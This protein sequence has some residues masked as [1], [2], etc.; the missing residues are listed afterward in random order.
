[1]KSFDGLLLGVVFLSFF[2]NGRALA[3]DPPDPLFHSAADSAPEIYKPLFSAFTSDDDQKNLRK[4]LPYESITLERTPCYG[5]CPVYTVTLYRSG[6]AELYAKSYLPKTGNFV[7][8]IDVLS[9]GRLCY[10]LDH[11]HFSD[12]KDSYRGS[13]TDDTTCIVTARTSAKVA[14]KVSDYG[15]VGPIELWAIHQVIDRMRERIEWKPK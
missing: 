10:L 14:K 13:W 8:K 5:T 1:M 9:F 4:N 11:F 3:A 6:M 2:A 12:F 7:G 15:S